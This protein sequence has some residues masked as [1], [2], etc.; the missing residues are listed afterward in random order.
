MKNNKKSVLFV[1]PSLST[2]GAEKSLWGLLKYFDYDKYD[3]DVYPYCAR[4]EYADTLD[5][6]VNILDNNKLHNDMFNK[7]LGASFKTLFRQ[8]HIYLAVLRIIWGLL[9]SIHKLFHKEYHRNSNLDWYIE[10]KTMQKNKKHYDVAIGYMEGGSNYYIVDCIDADKKIGWIH[11]D[12]STTHPNVYLEK[13]R[14]KKCAAIVTVSE[15][16]KREIL[17][18]MPEFEDKIHI[19]PNVIDAEK[20]N[21]LKML[22]AEE[23]KDTDDLKLVSVGRLVK[24]KGFD[25][26]IDAAALLKADG[27]KFKWYIIGGGEEKDALQNQINALKLNDCCYLTGSTDNPY[28]YVNK[29]DICVQMSAFE[30]R[31]MVVDEA[32]YL[33]KPIIASNIGAFNELITHEKTGIIVERNKDSLYDAI[34]VLSLNKDLQND[35]IENLKEIRLDDKEIVKTAERLIE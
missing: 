22:P 35:I 8:G 34:K 24:L 29:A 11:T 2:G 10:R 21:K 15:N 31:G 19:I 33:L 30:G 27:I 28:A 6:R 26:C 3:V 9:P 18:L 7:S 32:Q 17:K 5:K 25:I 12:Y 16:S 4:G 23:M 20:I 14:L 1:I 13:T